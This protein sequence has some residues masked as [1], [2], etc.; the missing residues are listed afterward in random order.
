MGLAMKRMILGTAVFAAL[1]SSPTFAQEAT[2]APAQNAAPVQEIVVTG[3]RVVVD[4]S[5]APTPVTVVSAS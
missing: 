4:G 3:S 2:R 1:P 5:Q